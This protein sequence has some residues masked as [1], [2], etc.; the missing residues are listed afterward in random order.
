MLAINKSKP[1]KNSN[2][3]QYSH[4]WSIYRL[5]SSFVESLIDVEQRVTKIQ[6][7]KQER[8]K[9]P[10][11]KLYDD[12]G[13]EIMPEKRP[14]RN[15]AVFFGYL[16]SSYYGSHYGV[17]FPTVE[18][19][20]FDA[21]VKAKGISKFNASDLNKNKF[22]RAA[23]TDKGVHAAFN[24]LSLKLY[25]DDP[26]LIEKVQQY[27]PSDIRIWGSQRVLNSFSART[28]CSSRFYEYLFPTY[29]LI[30][31]NPR[32][33]T[34]KQLNLKDS[35]YWN[36]R[37]E[38]LAK[39]YTFDEIL[40]NEKS[41]YHAYIHKT[42]DE[43]TQLQK[44]F[45]QEDLCIKRSFRITDE[46][47]RDFRDF[48]NVYKGRHNFHNFTKGHA[49]KDARCYRIVK[50]IEVSDPFINNGVEYLSIK[51]QGES[52][53]LHQ[54]RKMLGLVSLLVRCSLPKNKIE[55]ALDQNKNVHISKIPAA[56]LF[57]YNTDFENYNRKLKHLQK[58]NTES[59][60]L[61]LKSIDPNKYVNEL[62]KFK[63]EQIYVKIFDKENDDSF[64]TFNDYVDNSAFENVFESAMDL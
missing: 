61:I 2:F 27:L 25:A 13:K 7:N 35:Q 29:L 31:P 17:D 18:K 45:L 63:L 10:R 43:L 52:F 36:F 34:G 20:L 49:A 40:S 32:S 48:M 42:L 57:L 4:I 60:L 24:T 6:N 11:T 3:V 33:T 12:N 23:K 21:I 50:N 30:P 16:G 15:T 5:F 8:K 39:K 64:C 46:V 44:C 58:T 41:I 22:K 47:L 53:I 14:K 51:L 1:W 55:K 54:I 26:Q 56:G 38:I 62:E 28:F 19:E 9:E 59:Q 37:D